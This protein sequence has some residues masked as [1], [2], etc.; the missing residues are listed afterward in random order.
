MTKPAPR[1][2]SGNSKPA[3]QLDEGLIIALIIVEVVLAAFLIVAIVI[4]PLV[5]LLGLLVGE[6][7]ASI[8]AEADTRTFCDSTSL[9]PR[10]S[11]LACCCSSSAS[12]A[13]R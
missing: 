8:D 9:Y 7:D 3:K 1:P 4:I 2:P 6:P 11:A 5:G 13:P 10:M 12:L